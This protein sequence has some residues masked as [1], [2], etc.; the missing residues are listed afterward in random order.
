MIHLRIPAELYELMKHRELVE[1][2]QLM[3]VLAVSRS[4]APAKDDEEPDASDPTFRA[5]IGK[6]VRKH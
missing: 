3:A 1:V 5:I 2:V 6:N 4:A